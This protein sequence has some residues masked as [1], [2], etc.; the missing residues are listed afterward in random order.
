MHSNKAAW[1][2]ALL[3]ALFVVAARAQAQTEAK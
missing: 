2:V 1:V 3:A